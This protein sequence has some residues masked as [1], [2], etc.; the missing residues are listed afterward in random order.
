AGIRSAREDTLAIGPCPRAFTWRDAAG[1]ARPAA[2]GH[3]PDRR[4]VDIELPGTYRG[5]MRGAQM[6][7][8]TPASRA[9][10]LAEAYDRDAEPLSGYCRSLLGEPVGAAGALQHT[11]IIAAGRMGGLSDPGRLRAWLYA[12]ARNEC[13]RRLGTRVSS[14]PSGWAG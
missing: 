11:F 12:V 14:V 4:L 8:A 13:C 2:P 3:R 10:E 5:C 6:A 7:E 9:A 1:L